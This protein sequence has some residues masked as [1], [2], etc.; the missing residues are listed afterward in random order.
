MMAQEICVRCGTPLRAYSVSYFN[1]DVICFQCKI[2]EQQFP[3]FAAADAA[4][5]TAVRAGNIN[6]AGIGLG[7]ADRAMMRQLIARR[8][9]PSGA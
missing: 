6:F 7:E 1:T 4:E 8:K 9:E 3:G 2:E 5:A